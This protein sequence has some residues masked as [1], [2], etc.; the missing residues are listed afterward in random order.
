MMNLRDTPFFSPRLTTYH[1]EFMIMACISFTVTL[2]TVL[3]ITGF[4][5]LRQVFYGDYCTGERIYVL[6]VIISQVTV[7]GVGR[8]FAIS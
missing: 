2:Y 1:A 8:F 3:E 7:I 4:Y 5:S 6:Y